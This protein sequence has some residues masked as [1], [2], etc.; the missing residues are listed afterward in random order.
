AEVG[1]LFENLKSH[2]AASFMWS[3]VEN[4]DGTV[5]YMSYD[6][7]VAEMKEYLKIYYGD[8]YEY[9][10]EYICM[11]HKASDINTYI[12]NDGVEQN[13]CY[14]NRGSYPGEMFDYHYICDNYEYMRNLVLKAMALAEGNEIQRCEF[15][16]MSC[17]MLGLSAVHKSWYAENTDDPA[18][19]DEYIKRYDWVR[20]YITNHQVNNT[21]DFMAEYMNSD[22]IYIKVSP[23]DG[24]GTYRVVENANRFF[25]YEDTPFEWLYGGGTKQYYLGDEW[26]LYVRWG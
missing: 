5:S 11:Q 1:Y 7:F 19:K 9:I 20:D 6:E 2:L 4:E 17:E 26:I 23:D 21:E 24:K 16:L 3:V 8:G 22:S 15:I 14:I 18:K 10:Y 13:V 12:D 25:S